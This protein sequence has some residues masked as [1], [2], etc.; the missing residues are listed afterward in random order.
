M[1]PRATTSPSRILMLTSWS[2]VSTPAEL[3][4]ASVLMRPPLPPGRRL[5]ELDAAALGDAEIGA[6][7]DHPRAQLAP[8]DAQRVVGAVADLG[9]RLV[10]RLDVGA[11]AAE[12]QQ[13]DRRAQDARGS[14]RPASAPRP[15]RRAAR[16]ISG[17]SLI[18]FAL[19]LEDA[20]AGRDQLGVVVR[21]GRARQV[22]QPLAL[23]EGVCRIGVGIDEDVAVVEGRQQ[24]ECGASAACRCRTR[25][26][27][28]RR[29]RRR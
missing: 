18:D 27:T 20:A 7:A 17:V 2:E 4:I 11:D 24:P 13:V 21:P 15:R 26:P 22:E 23:G 16:R 5:R 3:S 28:C 14:A 12:P 29:R 6:F 25:R 10:R 8:V 19:A 9:V 1:S